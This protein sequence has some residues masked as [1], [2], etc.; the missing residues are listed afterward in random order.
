VNARIKKCGECIQPCLS[1]KSKVLLDMRKLTVQIV[2]LVHVTLVLIA[3]SE[4]S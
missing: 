1:Q 2:R 3:V 4:R